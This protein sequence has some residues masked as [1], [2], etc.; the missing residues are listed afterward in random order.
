MWLDAYRDDDEAV[1]VEWCADVHSYAFLRKSCPP[2]ES[3]H[4][5]FRCLATVSRAAPRDNRI[6]AVRRAGNVVGHIE[7]KCTDKTG[8]TE[9][10]AVLLI[11]PGHRGKGYGGD[12]IR[13]LIEEAPTIGGFDVMLAVCRPTNEAS[14]HLVCKFGFGLARQDPDALWFRRPFEAFGDAG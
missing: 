3:P 7:L 4:Q 9:R 8:P 2:S 5:L 14:V 13:A 12:A 6:W 10:E 1:F 11:A